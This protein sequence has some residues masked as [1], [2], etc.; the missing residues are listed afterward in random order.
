MK[1]MPEGCSSVICF[2]SAWMSLLLLLM[3]SLYKAVVCRYPHR[4]I[5]NPP[6]VVGSAVHSL[7]EGVDLCVGSFQ[8]SIAIAHCLKPCSSCAAYALCQT[9]HCVHCKGLQFRG[10]SCHGVPKAAGGVHECICLSLQLGR[11]E[12]CLQRAA[13]CVGL[14]LC[15]R[16]GDE[17]RQ[18]EV[19]R[20]CGVEEGNK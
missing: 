15:G 4:L 5:P 12:H 1:L 13:Q 10:R 2:S 17:G 19:E 7:L 6:C 8:A 11:C 3:C 9:R 16:G 18:A 20:R 14:R